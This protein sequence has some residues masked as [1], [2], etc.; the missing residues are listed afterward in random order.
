MVVSLNPNDASYTDTGLIQ[1]TTYYY[2][3]LACNSIGCSSES[4]IA[5]ATTYGPDS[6]RDGIR[7]ESDNCPW[8]SNADQE[9][10][11]G[12]G[13][14]DVC[15]NCPSIANPDQKDSNG[16]G[17]GDACDPTVIKL[18]SFTA[19]SSDKAVILKWTT[20]S[21]IDNA[22]FNIYRAESADGQYVKINPSLIQA[23]ASSTSG[24]TYKYVDDRVRNRTT[25][26][27]KLEDI[28]IY[29]MSTTH[30]PVSAVPRRL[31][32]D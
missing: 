22:G 25:Y 30:G 4:N 8:V 26:Y 27:Y 10:E 1:S 21:E 23:E 28:D 12:D 9:D 13:I 11:D 3:V 6:D 31:G 17:I 24:A 5:S 15:D 16:N 18:S 2:K 7:D 29:G 14:G 19:I 32:R 20:E